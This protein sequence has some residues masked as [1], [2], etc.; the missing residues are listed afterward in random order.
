MAERTNELSRNNS[1]LENMVRQL[2][3]AKAM[4]EGA[5]VAKSRFLAN[6]SHEIRTPMNGVLGMTELLLR[7]PLNG[8][9]RRIAETV[10][11]S[12]ESL[13][14]I[15]NDVLDIS[16]IEAGKLELQCVEFDLNETVEDVVDCLAQRAH[17]KE[18]EISCLVQDELPRVLGDP[19]G[20][21]QVVTNL[22]SNAI[23]FTDRG[24]VLVRTRS[25]VE[26]PSS[27]LVG[28]EVRDTGIG[29]SPESATRLFEMFAQGDSSTTRRHEGTGLGLAIS[30]QVAALM[31]GNIDLESQ[32][33][34]GTCFR[35][36][37]LFKRSRPGAE[38][39]PLPAVPNLRVLVVDAN[40]SSGAAVQRQCARLGLAAEVVNA[41]EPALARLREA[42]RS[43]RPFD[44]GL[45][46]LGKS[47]LDGLALARAIRED[48]RIGALR[49]VLLVTLDQS[50]ILATGAE[51]LGLDHLTKPLQ[52]RSL[53]RLL[54]DV[55]REPGEA[56]TAGREESSAP[57]P[58][59]TRVLL[60]EDSPVNQQVAY[61]LL[62]ALGCQARVVEN[63]QQALQA[64][65]EEPFDLVLMDCMMPVLDGFEAT[66][67]VRRRERA[68]PGRPRTYIVA[69]TASAMT[70]DRER[71]LKAGMDDFVAKP[72]SGEDLRAALARGIV[73][74]G[75]EVSQTDAFSPEPGTE[76][77][78]ATANCL[79]TDVLAA[80]ESLQQPGKPSLLGQ[81]IGLYVKHGPLLVEE[82]RSALAAEDV[83]TLRRTVHTLKSSSAN[84]G[85]KHL[86]SLCGELE[87]QL[88]EGWPDDAGRRF[89]QIE[90]EVSKVCSALLNVSPPAVA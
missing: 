46:E 13:L 18:L 81:V 3:A 57:L 84:V 38:P 55:D 61:G 12:G 23:K 52:L 65:A 14:A 68:D 20:V 15:I 16:R 42:A 26:E 43:G 31:G 39:E 82:A 40:A 37:A 6:I 32:V 87:T 83:P 69:V 19:Q 7:S 74:A 66:A 9:Q 4:A 8:Q 17:A 71:C 24:E 88:R 27:I 21:R 70:G 25:V 28:I 48:A 90:S 72:Y 45:L 89:S 75:K 54:L 77:L 78:A 80:L 51:N 33:G 10:R 5:S 67:E 50:A 53:V 35:F 86:S 34:S 44:L 49:L 41:A 1:E 85:A 64:M 60:A 58:I 11:R 22:V 76:R 2:R 30:K 47:G 73:A 56:A 59:G 79:D 63:G 29:I 36:T 62:V